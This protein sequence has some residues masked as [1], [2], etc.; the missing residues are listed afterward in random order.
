MRLIAMLP[1]VSSIPFP[2]NVHVEIEKL[3]QKEIGWGQK[4][5]FCFLC[6]FSL[7]CLSLSFQ[8]SYFLLDCVDFKVDGMNLVLSDY[9]NMV[10][11]ER[12][13]AGCTFQVFQ[14]LSVDGVQI[15]HFFLLCHEG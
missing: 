13:K 12:E 11:K 15:S 5:I 8:S 10:V 2:P 1:P 14:H 4:L 9:S 6:V 7:S 3:K